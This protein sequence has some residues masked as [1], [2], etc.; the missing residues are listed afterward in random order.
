M[1]GPVLAVDQ[2]NLS[3][4]SSNAAV[5]ARAC[6][7]ASLALASSC[8]PEVSHLS[9]WEALLQWQDGRVL[10]GSGSL[11]PPDCS[12]LLHLR[13]SFKEDRMSPVTSGA[14]SGPHSGGLGNL[15]SMYT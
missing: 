12:P 15:L 9:L 2:L 8:S 13:Q 6:Q 7:W 3:I 11:L 1:S 10:A 4:H 5:A 14:Y